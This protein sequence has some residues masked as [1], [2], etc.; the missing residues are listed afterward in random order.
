[1]GLIYF[2]GILS[3]VLIFVAIKN[4]I[5]PDVEGYKT[6]NRH[7]EDK[8]GSKTDKELIK[9]IRKNMLIILVF[10]FILL[11]ISICTIAKDLSSPYSRNTNSN[12]STISEKQMNELGYYKENGAWNYE[13]GD[14]GQNDGVAGD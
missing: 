6:R 2:F 12:N 3:L 8:W 7:L 5:K 4:F 9:S 13:G 1:M 11:G 10:S 14:A